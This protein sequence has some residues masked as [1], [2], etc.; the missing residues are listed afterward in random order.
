MPLG[1]DQFFWAKRVRELG[2][3]PEPIPRRNLTAKRLGAALQ[4]LTGDFESRNRAQV[5]GQA[6]REEDGVAQAVAVLRQFV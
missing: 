3:G 6:L 4:E 5:F 1:S 2:L